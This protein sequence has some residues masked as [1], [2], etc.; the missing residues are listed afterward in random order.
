MSG[1]SCVLQ[2]K[3][4]FAV[5]YCHVNITNMYCPLDT[6]T[7]TNQETKANAKAISF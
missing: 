6:N 3:F 5:V 1:R 4:M 2:R 7:I